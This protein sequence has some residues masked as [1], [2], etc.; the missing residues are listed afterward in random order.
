MKKDT[1]MKQNISS[2]K[3]QE[4]AVLKN[5]LQ[6]A[7]DQLKKA[8]K[9]FYRNEQ[10]QF[11]PL[12]A[13]GATL[14]LGDCALYQLIEISHESKAAPRKEAFENILS[15]LRMP[16]LNFIYLILGDS[17][18]VSLYFGLAKDLN[19]KITSLPSGVDV[20]TAAKNLL[21][22][23]IQGNFRGSKFLEEEIGGERQ[24]KEQSAE[25]QNI[26]N[27][28][29]TNGIW[30]MIE[31]VPKFREEGGKDD[32]E[33]QGV[34]RLIRIMQGD[35][36][37]ISIVATAI[38]STQ[39]KSLE[40]S[41][42]QL[43]D[44]L[45]PLAKRSLQ[46]GDSYAENQG[47]SQG[48]SKSETKG[49]NQGTSETDGT[50]KSDSNGWGKS[51][52]NNG[53]STNGSDTQGETWSK[54]ESK[55][56]SQSL[57]TGSNQNTNGGKSYTQNQS[58]NFEF[59][60]K[61]SQEFLKYLDE[62]LFTRLN[63]SKN[64]GA[65]HTFISVAAA[66]EL[67][68]AKLR[69]TVQALFSSET[70]NRSPLN[71]YREPGLGDYM[72]SFQYPYYCAEKKRETLLVRAALSQ[73]VVMENKAKVGGYQLPMGYWLSAQDLAFIPQKE[74]VGL[75]LKEEVEFGLNPNHSIDYI[76]RIEIGH[77]VQSGNPTSMPVFLDKQVLNKH[78]FVSGVTGSGK[79]TT[80]IKIL[81]E[82]NLPFLV[83]EPA[84]TE[85][86]VLHKNDPDLFIFT[87][88]NINIAPFLLN[89]FEFLPQENI[90]SRVD[91]IKANIEAAFDMEAAIPQIIEKALYQCY[92]DYGWNINTNKNHRFDDPFAEGVF[93]FPTLADLMR[94]VQQITEEQGF[95]ERLKRDYIGS[96]RARLQGLMVGSKG[97]MLNTPRSMDFRSLLQKKVIIELEEIRSPREK[98]LIMGFLLINLN[99]ALQMQHRENPQTGTRHITLIEE[100]HR[101]LSRMEAGDHP[102]KKQGVEALCD[103]LAEVRKYGEALI[104]ADQIPNKLAADVL[105]NTNTKIIHKIF[106]HDD[107]QAIGNIMALEDEQKD[108][109]SF[110]ETGR[111]IVLSEN[112][113]KP[114]QVKIKQADGLSTTEDDEIP[115]ED[116]RQNCLQFLL[117]CGQTLL[118]GF[119]ELPNRGDETLEAL[120]DL[121]FSGEL[122]R[123]WQ[124]MTK[125]DNQAL[126]EFLHSMPSQPSQDWLEVCTQ[127]I[128]H[129]VYPIEKQKDAQQERIAAI[130]SV[131]ATLWQDGDL[132]LL[133]SQCTRLKIK[134]STAK[135]SPAVEEPTIERLEGSEAEDSIFGR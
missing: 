34:D 61:H 89:P 108:F 41:L 62:E 71:L 9:L 72:Q 59:S 30:G 83:I 68:F 73:T 13:L 20:D 81:L 29:A 118:P 99:A 86:R 58:V 75:S 19:Q 122:V 32:A 14:Q 67:T 51:N 18:G 126:R 110:L 54:T 4:Q 10:P 95:D 27:Q 23:T 55:G 93:A 65:F 43:Y 49:S 105:K 107:K 28:F 63:Y 16:G 37:C 129:K 92:E 116:I 48:T 33:F 80:C 85:Y 1:I 7:D 56:A 111:A 74:V 12:G 38:P 112:F 6:F 102:S 135:K 21:L 8:E 97:A 125:N 121:L 45:T 57:Q 25:V 120:L 104:I 134:P 98:S 128:L 91:M 50:S 66:D 11:V 88:G 3:E 76:D 115:N 2:R 36:F 44:A 15:G 69:N 60:D 123:K 106:A 46:N 42:Y 47:H 131:L 35:S 101:L 22:P 127:I 17:K 53:D 103:M 24:P 77:L 109:F 78:I 70:D 26:L 79:T 5:N 40:Q 130:Q 64:K 52:Q 96:I 100:A 82:S 94:N 39:L 132:S 114:V 84:K 113:N 124:G 31:G 87:V 117:T 119:A 90:V 133:R